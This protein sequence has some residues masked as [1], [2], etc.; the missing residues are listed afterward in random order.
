MKQRLTKLR[1]KLKV[2]ESQQRIAA[3]DKNALEKSLATQLRSRQRYSKNHVLAELKNI[4][5]I[6]ANIGQILKK[7]RWNN[8]AGK[9]GKDGTG[10]DEE[11][12]VKIYDEEQTENVTVAGCTDN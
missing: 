4:K 11:H 10:H 7:G 9:E 8:V 3:V 6:T 5:A 1:H 12:F 2:L